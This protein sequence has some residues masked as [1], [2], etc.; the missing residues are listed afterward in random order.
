MTVSGTPPATNADL[1]GLTPGHA[2]SF[3]V[4]ATNA[5]GTGPPS[6]A[7]SELMPAPFFPLTPARICDTRSNGN[8]T[9]CVG[10]TLSAGDTLTVQV[11]GE[12]GVPPGASAVVANV[13]ATGATAESFLT[14]Y[15]EG[16]TRPLAS[17]LNFKAGQTVPNLVTVPLSASG[18]IDLY[19]AFGLGQHGRRRQRLLRTRLEWTGLHPA[20]PGPDL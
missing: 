15:P 2:Y 17:N 4:A 13:T 18:A 14:A 16:A 10:K 3:T 9:P 1:T 19:N 11:T 6:A 7:L 20:H 12:G 5:V 8:T